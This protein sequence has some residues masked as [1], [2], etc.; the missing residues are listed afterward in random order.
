MASRLCVTSF[1]DFLTEGEDNTRREELYMSLDLKIT[2]CDGVMVVSCCGRVVF[3]EE[4]TRLCRTVR[5]LLP[6]S[7]QIVLDLRAV[8]YI[9][10]SGLGALIGLVTSARALGGDVKL[11]DLSSRVQSLL[12]IT[13]LDTV[14]HTFAGQEE[15][16]SAFRRGAV[17]AA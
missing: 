8:K 3:G 9:D 13:R 4:T 1:T 10:S 2:R 11:C 7:P 14:I 17:A 16:I 6:E 15:A 12:Q 5:D